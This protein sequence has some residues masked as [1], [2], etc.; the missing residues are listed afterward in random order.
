[1]LNLPGASIQKLMN[2]SD[3]VLVTDSTSEVQAVLESV[4]VG[5][6]QKV[7]VY[8][9]DAGTD[10]GPHQRQDPRRPLRRSLP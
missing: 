4:T 2:V 5:S 1:M 10:G 6:M 9:E 3:S 8:Y 7:Y